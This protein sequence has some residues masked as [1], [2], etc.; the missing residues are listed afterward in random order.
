MITEKLNKEFEEGKQSEECF[1]FRA[2]AENGRN[3]IQETVNELERIK[4]SGRFDKVDAEIRQEAQVVL[5]VFK[6]ALTALNENQDF[7]N[8]TQPE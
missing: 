7:L 3:V 4:A 8:W 5:N 6:Q 1:A 2:T